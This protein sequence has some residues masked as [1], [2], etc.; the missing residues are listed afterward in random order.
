MIGEKIGKYVFSQK[1]LDFGNRVIKGSLISNIIIIDELGLLESKEK[2]L[3][4][5]I[6]EVAEIVKKS[7]KKLVILCIR[8]DVKSKILN[9]LDIEP[10]GTLEIKKYQ[11]KRTLEKFC[12]SIE[13]YVKL[14]VNP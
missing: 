9:L 3:Y 4:A 14:L 8:E 5:S 10:K 2:G 6:H 11:S 13:E 12:K 1:S 7:E